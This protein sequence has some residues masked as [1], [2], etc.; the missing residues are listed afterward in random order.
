MLYSIKGAKTSNCSVPFRQESLFPQAYIDLDDVIAQTAAAF[1]DVL[2]AVFGREIAFQDIFSFD[3]GKSFGLSKDELRDFLHRA[4]RDSVLIT[5][6]PMPGAKEVLERWATDGTFIVVVTGRPISTYD[7]TREWLRKNRIPFHGLL[8]VRKYTEN[9]F[10]ENSLREPIGLRT[11]AKSTFDFAVE[12]S[13]KMASYLLRHLGIPIA[14]F[15]RPWNKKLPK[16]NKGQQKLY[17]RC[18]NWSEVERWY[19]DLLLADARD[20]ALGGHE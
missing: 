16:V 6:R 11:L 5:L 15:D 2:R 12:D 4:H 14:L 7:V 8:F 3:L 13:P 20:T 19:E 18:F 1:P 10:P 17:S 9:R